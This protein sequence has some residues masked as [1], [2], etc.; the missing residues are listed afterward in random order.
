MDS[1]LYQIS[2]RFLSKV[3]SKNHIVKYL[4]FTKKLKG[5]IS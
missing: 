1:I 5:V 2:K 3:Y 4:V